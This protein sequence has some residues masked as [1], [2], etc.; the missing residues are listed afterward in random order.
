MIDLG[1]ANGWD[2]EGIEQRVCDLVREAGY[3]FYQ[4]S[5]E[6]HGYDTVYQCDE[7]CVRYH[8]DS[9]D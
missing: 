1:W 7:A 4:K 6:P 8:V 5:H 2:S 9:S 3:S